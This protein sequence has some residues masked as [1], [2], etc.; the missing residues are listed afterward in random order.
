MKR[1][2]VRFQAAAVLGDTTSASVGEE[3]P[4]APGDADCSTFPHL[5]AKRP[6]ALAGVVSEPDS[7]LSTRASPFSALSR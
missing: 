6:D 2:R 5:L 4:S 3:P 1:R 7:V